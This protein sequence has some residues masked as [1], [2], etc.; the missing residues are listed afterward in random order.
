MIFNMK[1]NG[2]I[3][4]KRGRE[5]HGRPLSVTPP[6]TLHVSDSRTCIEDM[7]IKEDEKKQLIQEGR[8]RMFNMSLKKQDC[9]HEWNL[10]EYEKNCIEKYE[11]E[12]PCDESYEGVAQWCICYKCRPIWHSQAGGVIY[13]AKEE[14]NNFLDLHNMIREDSK[15][16]RKR[17]K[18]L[19]QEQDKEKERKKEFKQNMKLQEMEYRGFLIKQ[20]NKERETI[21]KESGW[22]QN[23]SK[24]SG[25]IYWFNSRESKWDNEID[26]KYDHW[27]EFYCYKYDKQFWYSHKTK[28]KTWN[29]PNL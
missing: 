18:T 10:E 6:L 9:E 14:N 4:L 17:L 20:K 15:R 28:E 1:S 26:V 12:Y 7:R 3:L 29:N 13:K 19:K 22:K 25:K 11:N 27:L 8:Y 23:I 16:E 5:I 21:I 2:R 24:K